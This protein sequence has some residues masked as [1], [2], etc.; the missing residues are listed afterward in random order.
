[1]LGI[2][3]ATVVAMWLIWM[4]FWKSGSWSDSLACLF[5]GLAAAGL[6]V[7]IKQHNDDMK[8]ADERARHASVIEEIYKQFSIV[9]NI[10]GNCCI[11]LEEKILENRAQ[12]HKVTYKGLEAIDKILDFV[13]HVNNPKIGDKFFKTHPLSTGTVDAWMKSCLELAELIR[14]NK[15]LDDAEKNYYLRLFFS[16][17]PSGALSLMY[18]HHTELSLTKSQETIDLLLEQNLIM[19]PDYYK[20]ESFQKRYRMLASLEEDP[21]S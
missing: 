9:K 6:I 15:V 21:H 5:S 3:L 19:P 7:T 1:M 13:D 11:T 18:L 2:L 16:S 4:F 14:T 12:K 8:V 20:D 10:E 17:I